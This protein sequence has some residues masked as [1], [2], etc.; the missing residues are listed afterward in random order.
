VSGLALDG[1][2]GRH[3]Y[4]TARHGTLTARRTLP[5]GA[6]GRTAQ[7]TRQDATPSQTLKT[8]QLVIWLQS[9]GQSLAW[10]RWSAFPSYSFCPMSIS[11]SCPP[12]PLSTE[13]T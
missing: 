13:R 12:S 3:S 4:G 2:H 5:V 8:C 6:G 11:P 1:G 9:E 10:H 7:T